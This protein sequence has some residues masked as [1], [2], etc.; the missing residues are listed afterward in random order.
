METRTFYRHGD[1]SRLDKNED[2]IAKDIEKLSDRVFNLMSTLSPNTAPARTISKQQRIYRAVLPYDELVTRPKE[3]WAECQKQ[4]WMDA[5]ITRLVHLLEGNKPPELDNRGN[6]YGHSDRARSD[7]IDA[8]AG[9]IQEVVFSLHE[10]KRLQALENSGQTRAIVMIEDEKRRLQQAY[11]LIERYPEIIYF[12]E[13]LTAI[14]MKRS[15]WGS[16][17]ERKTK[18]TQKMGPMFL[19]LDQSLSVQDRNALWGRIYYYVYPMKS[20]GTLDSPQ[21]RV[22][23]DYVRN[24][25]CGLKDAINNALSLKMEQGKPTP[26]TIIKPSI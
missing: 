11:Q 21:P 14:E 22:M 18:I 2:R 23:E 6:H 1:R 8:K 17:T 13:P 19:L 4:A 24:R 3:I 16:E 5:S 12:D 20:D 7:I 10:I 26:A 25:I 15:Y 9:F